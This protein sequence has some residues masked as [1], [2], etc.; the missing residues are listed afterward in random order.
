MLSH[1]IVFFT[2]TC[3]HCCKAWWDSEGRRRI[4]SLAGSV[5][6]QC[7]GIHWVPLRFCMH[8]NICSHL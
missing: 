3:G 1:Y 7:Q 8:Y 5:W 6:Q 4:H 2:Q